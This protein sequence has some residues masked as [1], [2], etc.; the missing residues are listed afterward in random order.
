MVPSGWDD[1]SIGQ[2]IEINNILIDQEL[3]T[4][5]RTLE[6]LCLLTES[7]EWEDL[8]SAEIYKQMSSLY[9]I[10]DSPSK[11]INNTIDKWN[12]K[13]FNKFTVAEWIDMEKYILDR[14]WLNLIAL[15]YRQTKLDEWGNTI[16]EPYKYNTN[17]RGDSF[18]DYSINGL[19]GVIESAIEYRDNLLRSY[20]SVFEVMDES[21]FN[22]SDEEK[23]YLSDSEV[24]DIKKDIEKENVKK[25]YSWHKL[26]DDISGGNWSYSEAILD[27]PI[28]FIFNMLMMKKVYTP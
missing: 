10:Y 2:W 25:R 24:E 16:W 21:D 23:E 12:L 9:F 8:P 18:Y 20:S 19:F 3:S 14:E 28:T 5:S 1:I 7:D 13:P 27:L 4:F 22:P 17:E 15:C 26:L 6:L 11:K